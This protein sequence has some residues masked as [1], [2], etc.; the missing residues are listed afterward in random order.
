MEI[1]VGVCVWG[2]ILVQFLQIAFLLHSFYI[3]SSKILT[4]KVKGL[5][6]SLSSKYL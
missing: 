4:E 2:H 3:Q 6:Q 1:I 5:F